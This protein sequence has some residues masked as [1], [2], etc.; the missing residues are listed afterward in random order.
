MNT[1]KNCEKHIS[2]TFKYCPYCGQKPKEKLTLGVLFTNTISNY[3]SVDARFFKTVIPLLFKPGFLP[4]QFVNGKRKRYLHPAQMYLFISLVT[5]F[6]FSFSVRKFSSDINNNFNNEEQKTDTIVQAKPALDSTQVEEII[7]PLKETQKYSGISDKNIKALDSLLTIENTNT[8]NTSNSPSFMMDGT[9][10]DSLIEAKVPDSIIYK[11]MGMKDDAGF[12]M[13]KIYEQSL[14]LNK[15]KQLGSLL[16]IF[17]ENMP[18]A[19]FILLPIFA[20]ILK[21]LYFRKGN[22]ASHLVFSFYFFSFLF[23]I[24]S[25]L[26]LANFAYDIPTA[27]EVLI[28]LSTF[29]YLCIALRRFYNQ[30]RFTS[31]FK[32]SILTF[33]FLLIVIPVT[34]VVMVVW[35]FFVY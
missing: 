28:I 18:V 5:F 11:Q 8:V 15:T 1:C 13:R 20:F 31:V 7:T 4:K 22:Y 30:K 26:Y 2:N 35:S 32:G 16:D 27:I 23:L 24:F 25:L 6:I 9:K 29:I 12:F 21:V 34:F 17:Y 19:F 14:K 10:L 3:F 33:V